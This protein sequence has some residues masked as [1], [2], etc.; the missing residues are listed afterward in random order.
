M[1]FVLANLVAGILI[2]S[3]E[4]RAFLAWMRQHNQIYVGDEYQFRIGIFLSHSQFVKNHRGNYRVALNKF[5]CYTPAEYRSILGIQYESPIVDAAKRSGIKTPE[6][7]D[8]REKGA[9][10]PIQDQGSCGSCWAF[11]AIGSAEGVWAV[12]GNKLIKFSEQNLVDCVTDCHGCGGGLRD[13]AY[14]YVIKN[15]DGKFNAADDYPYTAT[16]ES[17]RFD[18]TKAIGFISGYDG[19]TSEEVLLEKVAEYG[20]VCI[21]MDAS[22]AHF[23]MYDGGIYD[24]DGWCTPES[25][26]HGL[27]CVGYGTEGEQ[28]FW[29][30]KN[31]WG[32]AW[33]EAGYV[34]LIRGVNMC[35]VGSRAYAA[36]P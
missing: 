2:H 9:V 3:H 14:D 23:Q 15:Q 1:F 20:P 25:I 11:G 16:Q 35:G 22:S 30:I 21:G 34:R 5:A 12:A 29:I 24:Y 8:W 33:G 10:T 4:E 27:V 31:S 13:K 32:T 18:A 6:A 26:N 7:I 28:N 17:C 36:K 19:V